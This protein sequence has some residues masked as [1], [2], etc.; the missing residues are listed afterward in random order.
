[1]A[2]EAEEQFVLRI[3]EPRELA[4]RLA[5]V[6][7]EGGPAPEVELHWH[8]AALKPRKRC[9]LL[10]FLMFFLVYILF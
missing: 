6:L 1:M 5:T 9:A 8:G 2:A 10:F 3:R 7:A 4:E